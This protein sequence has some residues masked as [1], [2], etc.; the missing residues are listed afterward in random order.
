M[1]KYIYYF[2]IK[3]TW[4]IVDGYCNTNRLDFLPIK[5]LFMDLYS[6]FSYVNPIYNNKYQANNLKRKQY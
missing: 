6:F 2:I 3:F 1:V 5:K 4:I